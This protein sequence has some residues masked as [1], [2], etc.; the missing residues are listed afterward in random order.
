M[1]EA[2]LHYA[3]E[4]LHLAVQALACH[5]LS[6]QERLVHAYFAIITLFGTDF[7]AELNEDWKAILPRF[8]A[9]EDEEG[10]KGNVGVTVAAMDTEERKS[11]AE[12][13]VSMA[14]RVDAVG[15]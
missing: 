12:A 15:R 7:P 1:P 14:F 8:T 6:L 9:L 5:D 4:K 11:L 13:L 10:T 3:R 2:P